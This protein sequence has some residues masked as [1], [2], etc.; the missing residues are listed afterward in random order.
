MSKSFGP[1]KALQTVDL[2]L[3]RGEVVALLGASG[4]GKSTL[5]KIASG[6]FEPDQGRI[7]INRKAVRFSSPRSARESGVVTVHQAT[8]QL[9]VAGISVV[10]NLG[11][12]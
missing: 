2:V 4:A 3:R 7:L 10:Q 6:V 5:A 11:F 1:T 8:A 9:G 12:G